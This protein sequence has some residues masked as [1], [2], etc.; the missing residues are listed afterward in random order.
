[1]VLNELGK[2]AFVTDF[3]GK[4]FSF[5]SAI[6]HTHPDVWERSLGWREIFGCTQHINEI[7]SHETL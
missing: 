3:R 2:A 4:E 5:G 6:V 1:M 7:Y